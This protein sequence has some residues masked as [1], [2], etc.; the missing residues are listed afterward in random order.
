MAISSEGLN[1]A[2]IIARLKEIFKSTNPT[3]SIGIGDD[4]AVVRTTGSQVLTTDMAV[5]G[6]HFRSDWSSALE[7]GRKVAAA[8]I[9]DV[10]AMSAQPEYLLVAVALTGS[11]TIEWICELASGIKYEADLAGA[12]VVGGDITRAKE[13]VISITAVGSSEKVVSRGGAQPGDGIYISSLTGWSAAGLEL[14]STGSQINSDAARKALQEYKAPTIDYKFDTSRATSLCDISDALIIQAA[15]MADLSQVSFKFNLSA[16]RGCEEF[17]ELSSLA[18]D[19]QFDIWKWVF[20]G[21]EDHALLATGKSL[22]GILIGEVVAGS[23]L[24]GVPVGVENSVW[25]HF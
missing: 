20:A 2:Q 11:E 24:Q 14:L 21:G 4:A 8:N 16:I 22:S 23:G 25:Q 12:S 15:Q 13:I 17:A 18:Q 10:L 19:L 3:I 9:A 6:V 7:I 1:E 5:A